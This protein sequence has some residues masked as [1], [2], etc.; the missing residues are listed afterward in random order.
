MAFSEYVRPDAVLAVEDAQ[1]DARFSKLPIVTGEPYVRFYTGA[2]LVTP[3]G[4][5]VGSLSVLDRYPKTLLARQVWQ[6][7]QL[8][9]S[10]VTA[11]EGRRAVQDFVTTPRTAAP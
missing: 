8:A 4:L 9:G 2:P 1:L 3:D 7:S 5:F 6:L 11:L 10:I